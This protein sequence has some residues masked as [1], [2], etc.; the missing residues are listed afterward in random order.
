MQI[1]CPLMADFEP[2]KYLVFAIKSIRYNFPGIQIFRETE[3]VVFGEIATSGVFGGRDGY[4]HGSGQSAETRVS[5]GG[6]L[7]VN[8]H[9]IF[10]THQ[11][12]LFPIK[13]IK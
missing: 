9:P 6:R 8:Q 1:E 13:N 10:S 2:F 12:H 7:A 5:V 4:L 3:R 11:R